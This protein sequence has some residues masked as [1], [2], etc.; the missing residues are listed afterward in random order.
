MRGTQGWHEITTKVAIFQD[1]GLRPP[2]AGVGVWERASLQ[3]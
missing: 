3:T 1:M 2:D